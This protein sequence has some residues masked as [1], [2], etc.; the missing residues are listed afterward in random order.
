[1]NMKALLCGCAIALSTAYA[2]AETKPAAPADQSAA[3]QPQDTLKNEMAR[4]EA[5]L[6]LMPGTEPE[7]ESAPTISLAP[8]TQSS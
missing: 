6:I 7:D 3:S 8:S 4:E 2:D 1:M 5:R